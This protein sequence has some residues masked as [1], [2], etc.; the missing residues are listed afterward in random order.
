MV[1]YT[2]DFAALEKGLRAQNHF[3]V[4]RPSP[5][6]ERREIPCRIHKTLLHLVR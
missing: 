4:C 5:T 2:K 1:K 3:T 6:G